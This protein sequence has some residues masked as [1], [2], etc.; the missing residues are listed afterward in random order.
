MSGGSQPIWSLRPT[1]I[2]RS[3]LF[4]LMKLGFGSTWCGSG[5]PGERVGL[6]LVA[7]DFLRER[8][9]ILRRRN[10]FA[11]RRARMWQRAPRQ[12]RRQ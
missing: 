6:D 2:S 8:F 11:P 1:T 10:H 5:S 7:A 12:A 3:A 9:E 4:N